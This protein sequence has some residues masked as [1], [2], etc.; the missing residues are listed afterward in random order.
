MLTNILL[1]FALLLAFTEARA[2]IAPVGLAPPSLE[3][4]RTT[5]RSSTVEDIVSKLVLLR[6][7]FKISKDVAYVYLEALYYKDEDKFKT[8][9]DAYKTDCPSQVD[10][11]SLFAAN[12]EMSKPTT[13][14][15]K[16]LRDSILANKMLIDTSSLSLTNL[17]LAVILCAHT[18]EVTSE[19]R[20]AFMDALKRNNELAAKQIEAR[21][22]K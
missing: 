9:L 3:T 22:S 21:F 16:E 12:L 14:L 7:L 20:K 13:F 1:I 4:I 6:P 19:T 15:P 17:M 8:Q 2:R 10:Y 18:K 11:L 5:A